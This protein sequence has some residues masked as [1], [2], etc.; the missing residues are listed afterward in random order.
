MHTRADTMVSAQRSIRW[1]T[2]KGRWGS[3]FKTVDLIREPRRRFG[4]VKRLIANKCYQDR[5][6][7]LSFLPSPQASVFGFAYLSDH[8]TS[9]YSRDHLIGPKPSRPFQFGQVPCYPAGLCLDLKSRRRGPSNFSRLSS[10]LSCDGTGQ[11]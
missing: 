10:L 2:Q 8:L 7:F 11:S 3:G 6:Y 4:L 5:F 9:D 1:R